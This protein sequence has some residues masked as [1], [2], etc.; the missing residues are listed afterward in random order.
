MRPVKSLFP[1]DLPDEEAQKRP[2][3]PLNAPGQNVAPRAGGLTSGEV[4]DRLSAAC[5]GPS[6]P[7]ANGNGPAS[8]NAS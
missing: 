1:E 6:Q 7:P 4:S 2:G 8:S 5:L 3:Q